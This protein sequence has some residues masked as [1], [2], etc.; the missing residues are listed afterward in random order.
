MSTIKLHL[1]RHLAVPE[2]G[3]G[4]R[5]LFGEERG[6]MMIISIFM[7]MLVVAM[8]YYVAGIGE[9]IVYRER[10]QDAADS[11]AMAGAVTFA[12]AMNMV[13]LLNLI[14]ASVLAVSV[15]FAIAAYGIEKGALDASAACLASWGECCCTA[16]LCLF[17]TISDGCDAHDDAQEIAQ[18]VA[19]ASDDAQDTLLEW[20]PE[21]AFAASL[22]VS[23]SY[24]GFATTG[25]VG[26][27]PPIEVDERSRTTCRQ[28]TGFNAAGATV[29]VLA[30]LTAA[31]IAEDCDEGAG[32]AMLGAGQVAFLQR[33]ICNDEFDEI[34][35]KPRRFEDD[36]NMG[37]G[38]FQFRAVA[39]AQGDVNPVTSGKHDRRVGVALWD[40]S[41]DGVADSRGLRS[42]T[43]LAVAQSE[44]YLAMDERDRL[45]WLWHMKWRA[46]L[47]RVRPGDGIPLAGT[48]SDLVIH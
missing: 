23:A 1:P 41:A 11:S 17:G 15:I 21:A 34:E 35:A 6:A 37:G 47:R 46:R 25:G 4:I 43:G 42:V 22:E 26:S 33:L 29:G 7:A 2:R 3:R 31:A 36:V 14:M 45:E 48:L 28:I 44:Y 32:F 16:A 40:T 27:A 18:D 24:G 9:T 8:L 20:V 30:G 19:E 10:L 13:S 12:R 38:D 39:R 5:R